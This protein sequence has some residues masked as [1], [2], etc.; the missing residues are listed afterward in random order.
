MR[1]SSRCPFLLRL[2]AL[3]TWNNLVH[4][5]CLLLA[6]I[7][8]VGAGAHIRSNGDAKE[9]FSTETLV[10]FLAAATM[11]LLP[12]IKSF[13]FGGYSAEFHDLKEEVK[14]ARELAMAANDIGRKIP[15]NPLNPDK[16]LKTPDKMLDDAT[17]KPD[18]DKEKNDPWKGKFGGLSKANGRHLS[19]SVEPV[20]GEKDWFIV[21][22]LV[23]PTLTGKALDTPVYFYIHSDFPRSRLVVLPQHSRAEL[24]LRAWGAFTVGVLTDDGATRLELDLAENKEFPALF[25]SR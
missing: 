21:R 25:R 18:T 7:F 16:P 12:R 8:L 22:L 4:V 19:A 13:S 24:R 15:E 11:L 2:S 23:E 3:V 14:Q 10:W 1:T 17:I 9:R 6:I 5:V 20:T